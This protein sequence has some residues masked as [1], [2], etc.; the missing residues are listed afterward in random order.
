[1]H[2]AAL[3]AQTHVTADQD[4][5]RDRLAEHL[6]AQDVG[7]QLFRFALQVRVD[8]GDV[9]VAADDVAQC[10]EALLDALDLDGRR[11]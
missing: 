10:G 8:N 1:M 11:E 9:V 3:V 5:V 7:D 4:V 2:D 6:D